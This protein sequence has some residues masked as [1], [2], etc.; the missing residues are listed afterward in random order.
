MKIVHNF[1]LE[2]QNYVICNILYTELNS[3]EIYLEILNVNT[4]IRNAGVGTA[5]MKDFIEYCKRRGFRLIKLTV[6]PLELDVNMN[7]LLKFYERLG[8][9]STSVSSSSMY[10]E[11]NQ[12]TGV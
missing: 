11:I 9:R 10:L 6:L 8:F 2:I 3:N 7:R 12:N 1:I 4:F 5:V